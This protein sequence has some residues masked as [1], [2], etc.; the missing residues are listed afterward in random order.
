MRSAHIFCGWS[1][2]LKP[3]ESRRFH[4]QCVAPTMASSKVHV[5]DYGSATKKKADRALGCIEREKARRFRLNV[6]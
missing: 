1:K 5:V 6:E 2:R 3:N 4:P